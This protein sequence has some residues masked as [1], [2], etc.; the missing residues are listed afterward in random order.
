MKVVDFP[1]SYFSLPE[2]K[3]NIHFCRR[4]GNIIDLYRFVWALSLSL[5]LSSALTIH[6]PK[7]G[8]SYVIFGQWNSF[9]QFECFFDAPFQSLSPLQDVAAP[10][11][12]DDARLS[13]MAMPNVQCWGFPPAPSRRWVRATP[14]RHEGIPGRDVWYKSRKNMDPKQPWHWLTAC[15]F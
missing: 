5:S 4:S 13:T 8:L 9:S 11:A 6:V 2:C 1:A 14:H 12:S 10:S 7:R 3:S 15:E